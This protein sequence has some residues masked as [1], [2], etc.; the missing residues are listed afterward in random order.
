MVHAA[1]DQRFWV[2]QGRLIAAEIPGTTFVPLPRR[3]HVLAD[4]DPA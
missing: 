3:N 2:E 1:N 4:Y